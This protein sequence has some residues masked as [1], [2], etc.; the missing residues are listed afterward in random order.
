MKPS[1]ANIDPLAITTRWERRVYW[2]VCG[3][4]EILNS[5]YIIY[6]ILYFK[7]YIIYCIFY[8]DLGWSGGCCTRP[9]IWDKQ[10][11]LHPTHAYISPTKV[12]IGEH[13]VA[14][15]ILHLGTSWASL[16]VVKKVEKLLRN[17]IWTR[18][19]QREVHTISGSTKDKVITS[20]I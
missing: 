10:A 6:W 9:R 1:V 15:S 17:S 19:S 20:P 5:K 18:P 12:N 3:S 8:F 13:V 14:H 11:C 7:L 16:L 2:A 4:H